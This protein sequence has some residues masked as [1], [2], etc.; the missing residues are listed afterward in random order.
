MPAKLS[1]KMKAIK[2]IEKIIL[3]GVLE[4]SVQVRGNSHNENIRVGKFHKHILS[5]IG[6]AE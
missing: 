5:C 4:Q 1:Y 2:Y 3:G 6:V